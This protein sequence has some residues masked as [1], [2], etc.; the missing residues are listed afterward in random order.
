MA[1]EFGC[2]A[3]FPLADTSPQGIT[4]TTT[5]SSYTDVVTYTLCPA[6]DNSLPAGV[7]WVEGGGPRALSVL[8]AARQPSGGQPYH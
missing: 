1:W 3:A 8:S 2:G 4:F 7:A 6:G 5:S